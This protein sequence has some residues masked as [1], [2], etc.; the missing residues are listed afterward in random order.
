MRI[1]KPTSA[2]QT[3]KTEPRSSHFSSKM[4]VLGTQQAAGVVWRNGGTTPPPL[5]NGKTNLLKCLLK[6][7]V[8]NANKDP[9]FYAFEKIRGVNV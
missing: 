9:L 2:V 6:R 3:Y 4:L 5:G 1:I 8:S 7:Y